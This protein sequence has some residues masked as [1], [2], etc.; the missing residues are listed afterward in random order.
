MCFFIEILLHF[1][2]YWFLCIWVFWLHVH[3]MCPWC[4]WRLKEGVRFP[5]HSYRWF[6]ATM[7]VLGIKPR[8]TVRTAKALNYK[9]TSPAPH[10]LI[11][12]MWF[13]F[14]DLC[15]TMGW[16]QQGPVSVKHLLSSSHFQDPGHICNRSEVSA[17]SNI[18]A[19]ID[20][21]WLFSLWGWVFLWM[22]QF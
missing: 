6:W 2:Y 22:C 15:V 4:P 3:C 20:F 11:L 12:K 7:W 17:R 21:F 1:L 18:Y 10:T 13:P 5:G 16:R 8:T 14:I 19:H 9:T